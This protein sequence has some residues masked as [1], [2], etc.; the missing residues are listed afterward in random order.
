MLIHECSICLD[1]IRFSREDDTNYI[2]D[3][4]K[5]ECKHVFHYSCLYPWIQG[6][7]VTQERVGFHNPHDTAISWRFV[8]GRN[9]PICRSQ[10][11]IVEKES[12]YYNEV[13]PKKD[14]F[15]RKKRKFKVFFAQLVEQQ[16]SESIRSE[17][18]IYVLLTHFF[19]QLLYARKFQSTRSDPSY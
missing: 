15:R 17:S 19:L 16:R 1:D 4:C 2:I 11:V 18:T 6:I 14:W 9:C 5:L 13:K 7:K 12:P 3:Y 10:C 8:V